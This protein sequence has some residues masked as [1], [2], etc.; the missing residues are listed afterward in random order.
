[1]S[2]LTNGCTHQQYTDKPCLPFKGKGGDTT[3]ADREEDEGGTLLCSPA[4]ERSLSTSWGWENKCVLSLIPTGKPGRQAWDTALCPVP[5]W[6]LIF[7]FREKEPAKTLGGACCD[8]S[9]WEILCTPWY[10]RH[11]T[12]TL[13]VKAREGQ[14]DSSSLRWEGLE[15]S[16]DTRNGNSGPCAANMK[17]LG[18][19]VSAIRQ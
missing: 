11:S 5:G 9:V 8:Q 7:T 10:S 17:R 15:F 3:P 18:W 14:S 6:S 16:H 4:G 2:V 12:E 19:E 1:M 13:D